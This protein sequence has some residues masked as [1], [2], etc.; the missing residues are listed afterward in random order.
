ML[1][2]YLLF[3]LT[4]N[5]YAQEEPFVRILIAENIKTATVS[6]NI[7]ILGLITPIVTSG[8]KLF[9]IT[10]ID[11]ILVITPTR[12]FL[13]F[14]GQPYRGSLTLIPKKSGFMVIN[15]ILLEEYLYSVLPSEIAADWPLEALK[16]QAVAARCYALA[17]SYAH[18]DQEFDLYNDIRSQVYLG[19]RVE[20]LQTTKAVDET[21]G[22]VALYQGEIIRAYFYASAGGQTANS[23]DVWGQSLPYL[24]SVNDYDQSSPHFTWKVTYTDK[25]ITNM[26]KSYEI[27]IGDIRDIVPIKVDASERVQI[28]R[29]IGQNDEIEITGKDFRSFLD[30][31]STKFLINNSSSN[32][33]DPKS[34][35]TLVSEVLGNSQQYKDNDTLYFEINGFGWGHG[36]GLSQWGAR[37]MALN[38]NDYSQI[39]AHYYQQTKIMQIYY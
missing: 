5:V 37:A 32:K 3:F 4:N 19:I 33:N 25:E 30:L 22:I 27:E 34:V 20:N 7:E 29:L 18:S 16:A 24:R 17:Q 26:L 12:G 23:E 1:I 15:R 13:S 10:E 6:G 8:E 9:S 38:G 31:K 21:R 36:V 28:L 39:L 35:K 2:L 11:T 14:N